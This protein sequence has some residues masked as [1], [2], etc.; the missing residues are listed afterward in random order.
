MANAQANRYH[1]KPTLLPP[2]RFVYI[3]I[4]A[5]RWAANASMFAVPSA[6]EDNLESVEG[7]YPQSTPIE[8]RRT[9]VLVQTHSQRIPRTYKAPPPLP[10]PK[11]SNN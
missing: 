5:F 1:V 3:D 4:S 9:E 8:E 7:Q 10:P 2:E 6:V 11:K